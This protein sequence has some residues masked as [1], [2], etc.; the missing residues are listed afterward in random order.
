MAHLLLR[1]PFIPKYTF[2][3]RYNLI[4]EILD[5]EVIDHPVPCSCYM[6][7]CILVKKLMTSH[8][9]HAKENNA[10]EQ[11]EIEDKK[12]MSV[13]NDEELQ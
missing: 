7:K 6:T 8:E 12:R 2:A 4:V 3:F 9:E 11:R 10:I 5:P 13:G 1:L